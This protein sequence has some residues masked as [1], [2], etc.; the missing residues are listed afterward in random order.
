MLR[1]EGVEGLF[2]KLWKRIT[3][4]ALYLKKSP[5]QYCW[6]NFAPSDADCLRY[7]RELEQLERRPLISIVLPVY[8]PEEKFL[9]EAIE[10]VRNQIYPDWELCIADDASTRSFV[11]PVLERYADEDDRIK[12]IFREQNGHISASSNSALE[13]VSGEFVAL[14]DHDDLLAPHAL[15]KMATAILACSDVDI[16]YSNEDKVDAEG[17]H[18]QPG[19]KGRWSPE[20]FL[21]FMYIGH[22]GLYRST[23]VK[24]VGGFRE[25]FEGSQD[26]DLALRIS[27][28]A[29]QVLHIPEIL[30]HWRMHGDSVAANINAKPYAF[31]S[32]KRALTEAL[33]R[34]GEQAVEV[35][36]G[37]H[38]GVYRSRFAVEPGS[39]LSLFIWDPSVSD[40]ARTASAFAGSTSISNLQIVIG[41][42]GENA[43]EDIVKDTSVVIVS[44][45]ERN[46]QLA[47]YRKAL[48]ITDAD[49]IV[50]TST[51]VKPNGMGWIE[52]LLQHGQRSGVGVVGGKILTAAG[53][54][55][56]AGYIVEAAQ[57]HHSQYGAHRLDHGYGGRV[58]ALNNVSA[59]SSE[60]LLVARK[61]LESSSS[62]DQNYTEI[63]A[64]EADLGLSVAAGGARVVFTPHAVMSCSGDVPAR[65]IDLERAPAD[66]RLLQERVGIQHYSDPFYPEG[67]NRDTMNFELS[68]VT[69]EIC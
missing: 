32:A 7:Q 11:R 1:H 34:R 48:E 46:P 37:D 6:E 47:F 14:L 4:P 27:E 57:I 15:Y 50:L 8:N 19:F 60:C 38:P 30:Y 31:T 69:G 18:L 53:D 24:K 36:D 25:G 41:Q 16:I 66:L 21:S 54:V 68:A 63:G 20:Y 67:L 42:P 58:V 28:H 56:H 44:Q 43:T 65:M 5:P 45:S 2:D 13:L 12:V 55:V 10:S 39:A 52:E 22:L 59:V 23:L 26:Y 17:V 40:V 9:I 3:N 29:R 62:L 61:Q 35:I 33:I 49:F 64:F 51:R